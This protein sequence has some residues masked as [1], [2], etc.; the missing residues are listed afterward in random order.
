MAKKS[1]GAHAVVDADPEAPSLSPPIS[2]ATHTTRSPADAYTPDAYWEESTW[3]ALT[4]IPE[5]PY[6]VFIRYLGFRDKP[7]DTPDDL[8]CTLLDEETDRIAQRLWAHLSTEDLFKRAADPDYLVQEIDVLLA[9]Y[10]PDIWGMDADR[11]RLLMPLEFKQ[12][13]K[14]LVYEDD[15]DRKLLW[16][17]IHRW[18]FAKAFVVQKDKVDSREVRI[19]LLSRMRPINSHGSA[20]LVPDGTFLPL[21]HTT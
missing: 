8:V 10:A 21:P 12:Y 9:E 6:M 7:S 14:Q 19:V 1:K 3:L 11:S 13:Q 4:R 17:H 16:L 20:F 18:M 15:D 2:A 5:I